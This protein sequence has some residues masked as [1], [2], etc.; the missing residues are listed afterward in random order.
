M[1]APSALVLNL[2]NA[3]LCDC[4]CVRA[5][6]VDEDN[7]QSRRAVFDKT[8][9]DASVL[10]RYVEKEVGHVPKFITDFLGTINFDHF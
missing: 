5:P 1:L 10:M 9:N 6:V 8:L 2:V 3:E 7:I 4:V